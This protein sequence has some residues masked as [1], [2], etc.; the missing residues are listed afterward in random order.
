MSNAKRFTNGL[1]NVALNLP[2]GWKA[3]STGFPL[4]IMGDW[5][6]A[7]DVR[8]TGRPDLLLTS[9]A[10]N[11]MDLL[12]HTSGAAEAWEATAS[13]AMP[14][15]A[16][17]VSNAVG[18]LDRFPQPDFVECFEQINPWKVEPPTQA[19]VVYRFHDAAGK[20][21]ETP[22]R[23]PLFLDKVESVNYQA[24]AIGDVDGDGR[25]DIVVASDTGRVRVFLQGAGGTFYEQKNPGMDQPDTQI[26]DVKI[27][28]LDH[29]GRAS[30]VFAGSPIG[31]AGGGGVFVYQ[32]RP[33]ASEKAAGRTP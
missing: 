17:V 22:E 30:I 20:P 10:Q 11:A 31:S 19:C 3:S 25:N 2:G 5:I 33:A 27:A 29:S 13:L 4:G 15:N 18:P 12:F 9:R 1:V 26:F 7:G 28:D 6:S 24:A 16:F 8:G 14:V 21:L 23:V 32:A